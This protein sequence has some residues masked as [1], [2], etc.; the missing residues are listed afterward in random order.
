M[1]RY[2]TLAEANAQVPE[3]RGCFV[4]ILQL[5]AQLKP[6]Y[7]RL[8]AVGAAPER[9]D[10]EV[11]APG[12]TETALRDRASF[13]ALVETLNDEIK[14]IGAAGAVIKD[15]DTGLVDWLA[16]RRGQDIWLCWRLG[17]AGIEY[18]HELESGFTGRRPVAELEGTE[19]APGGEPSAAR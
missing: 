4:R 5:R 15:L 2:Y 9:S 16:C 18:W 3:V 1:A 13:K 12:L 8:E 14:A 10:F 7:K 17:E 6:I 19:A 11:H